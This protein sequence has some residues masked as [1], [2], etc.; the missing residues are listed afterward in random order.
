MKIVNFLF[1][2]LIGMIAIVIAL[3]NRDAVTF[4]LDPFSKDHPALAFVTP[5]YLLVFLAFI[6]GV[7]IGGVLVMWTGW[8]RRSRARAKQEEKERATRAEKARLEKDT[9]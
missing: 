1:A 6:A 7:L 5:L 4:S 2:S 8:R 3:A 9:P